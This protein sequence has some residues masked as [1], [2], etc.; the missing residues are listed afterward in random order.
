MTMGAA[1]TAQKFGDLLAGF[2]ASW[3]KFEC[4]PA[5][6]ISAERVPLQRY[7]DTGELMPPGE[8][9][10]WQDWLDLMASHARHGRTV[11]RVRVLAE[12]PTA[13]QRYLMAVSHW[14]A[15]AGERISYLPVSV[16][17]RLR[18]PLADDWSLFDGT[19]VAVTRFTAAREVESR[20]LITDP[21]EVARYCALRDLALRAASPAR[22]IAAA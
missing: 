21:A 19:T 1:I 9:G 20:E 8:F 17:V 10:W 22:D 15:Q 4:Q 13:Y 11:E 5:Y 6:A 14:H 16:A 2:R 7:L 3:F 12:P 18:L